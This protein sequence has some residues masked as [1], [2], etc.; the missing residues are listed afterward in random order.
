MLEAQTNISSFGWYFFSPLKI[1]IDLDVH[2][3]RQ[4]I[5]QEKFG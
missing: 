4:N 3:N 2:L 5:F 1:A